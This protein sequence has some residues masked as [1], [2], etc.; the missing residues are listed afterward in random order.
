VGKTKKE[1]G[2]EK[3]KRGERERIYIYLS[4]KKGKEG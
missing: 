1:E 4:T 2:R 3:K